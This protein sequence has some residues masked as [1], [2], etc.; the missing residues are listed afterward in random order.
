MEVD[1]RGL[2][3]FPLKTVYVHF[4]VGESV[5]VIPNPKAVGDPKRASGIRKEEKEQSTGLPI[6]AIGGPP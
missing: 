4:H 2:A 1:G 6:G 3:V 5:G